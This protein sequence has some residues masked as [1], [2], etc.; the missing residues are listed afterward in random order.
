MMLLRAATAVRLSDEE[1]AQESEAARGAGLRTREIGQANA[2]G[3]SISHRDWQ[4]LDEVRLRYRRA[5]GAFFEGFDVLLCPV[6]STA[7]FAH[8]EVPPGERTLEVNGKQVPFENQLFWAGYA[9]LSHL[10]ATVAPI[11][12]TDQGLP[13]GV[14]II[15]R[16]YGDL[17]CL[18]FASLLEQGYRAF[19]P[20]PRY[21]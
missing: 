14:Q 1:F 12:L 3:A 2:F 19:A 7:A 20:P 4:R 15:G 18:R 6:L 17:T 10:P 8:S 9:G 16:P 5:W 13:V 11:G 21:A